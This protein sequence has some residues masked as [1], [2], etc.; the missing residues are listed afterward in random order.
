MHLDEDGDATYFNL[1]AFQSR[2]FETDSSLPFMNLI[3]VEPVEMCLYNKISA[4]TFYLLATSVWTM[5]SRL[6][7]LDTF[8]VKGQ[9]V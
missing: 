3:S 9:S 2:R 7:L 1:Y 8:C 6:G 5:A 4:F